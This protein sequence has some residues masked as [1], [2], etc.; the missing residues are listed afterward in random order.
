MVVFKEGHLDIHPY[1]FTKV[2]MCVGVFS[3]EYWVWRE[4]RREREEGEG[5]ERRKGKGR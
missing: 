3:T 4:G 5:G 1:K 2:A